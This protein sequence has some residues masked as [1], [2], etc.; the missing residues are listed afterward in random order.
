MQAFLPR[1]IIAATSAVVLLSLFLLL[2][3]SSAPK[4][5]E[6]VV[7]ARNKAAEYAEFGNSHFRQGLY[8]RA[9]D[10]FELSLA[11]NGPV[12]NQPGMVSSYN[13]LGRVYLAK[14]AFTR[15]EH[16]RAMEP[17]LEAWT[18]VRRRWDPAGKI[19]SALSVRLLGDA[20]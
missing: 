10:F 11:Y 7:E 1:R 8:D 3:C 4:P 5:Q 16:F 9:I 13:S 20:P 18:A 15:P 14:D 12:D 2:A 19:R 6:E 17:R